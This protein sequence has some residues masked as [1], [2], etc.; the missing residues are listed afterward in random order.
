[1][2]SCESVCDVLACLSAQAQLVAQSSHTSVHL[3]QLM[4]YQPDDK[5]VRWAIGLSVVAT[6]MLQYW[7]DSNLL[8]EAGEHVVCCTAVLLRCCCGAAAVLLQDEPV[9]RN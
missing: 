4:T 6:L 8:T 2:L 7:R 1:M 5:N 9:T 3:L